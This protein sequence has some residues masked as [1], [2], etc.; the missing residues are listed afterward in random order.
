MLLALGPAAAGCADGGDPGQPPRPTPASTGT[1]TSTSTGAGSTAPT[2]S[3]AAPSVPPA[4]ELTVTGEVV[5]GVE[6]NC[7]IL[8]ADGREYQL[9]AGSATVSLPTSGRVT[10]TGHPRTDL[11]TTCMQGV[12]L[13]VRQIRPA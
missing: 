8:R 9:V 1:G 6:P 11:A 4:G 2:G 10:V 3:G 7:L 12:P 5:S 13:V